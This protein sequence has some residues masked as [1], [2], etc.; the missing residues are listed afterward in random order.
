MSWRTVVITK[1]SKLDLN[2]GYMVIRD[3]E[4]S[5]RVFLDEIAILICETPAI[6]LTCALLEACVKNKIKVIFCDRTHSPSAELM[7]YHTSYNSLARIEEQMSW[8]Q[9]TKDEVWDS[10]VKEKIRNQAYLLKLRGYEENSKLLLYCVDEV[11]S[12]D[13]SNREAVAAKIYFTTLFGKSFSRDKPLP[14]NKALNYG[15]SLLLG[16]FNRAIASLGYLTQ[17][18]LKH[19]NAFNPFNFSCDLLEPFRPLVDRRVLCMDI[20]DFSTKEKHDLL[21]IFNSDCIIRDKRQ[22]IL[23]AIDLYVHSIIRALNNKN[24]QEVVPFSLCEVG[25]CQEDS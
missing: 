23:N 12:G 20:K 7:P 11:S 16:A 9:Q 1:C 4:G 10:I 14:V 13:I 24:I 8:S 17:V 22:S 18:G 3:A 2:L 6:S 15:Y 25:I 5:K 19:K 21:A